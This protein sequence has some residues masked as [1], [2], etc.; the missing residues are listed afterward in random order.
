MNERP[1]EG[2]D[3]QSLTQNP[4]PRYTISLKQAGVLETITN[5]DWMVVALV[6]H[7]QQS[8]MF[9]GLNIYES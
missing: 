6:H 9:R 1:G 4:I 8:S 7:T 5:V 3:V 2:Q